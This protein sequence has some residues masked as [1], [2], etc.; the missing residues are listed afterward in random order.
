MQENLSSSAYQSADPLRNAC[1][2]NNNTTAMGTRFGSYCTSMG[3]VLADPRFVYW[4]YVHTDDGTYEN[5]NTYADIE[6]RFWD[7]WRSN[8]PLPF[9]PG[10]FF[11]KG[12]G[13]IIAVGTNDAATVPILPVEIDSYMLG[14]YGGIRTKGKDPIGQESQIQYTTSNASGRNW[15]AQG[16]NI[17]RQGPDPPYPDPTHPGGDMLIWPWTRSVKASAIPAVLRTSK[18]APLCPA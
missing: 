14:G 11:Y 7:M 15:V 8:K 3:S 2:F 12:N 18:A 9:L 6:Y 10:Q 17:V 5:R 13:P 16:G 4:T 1:E